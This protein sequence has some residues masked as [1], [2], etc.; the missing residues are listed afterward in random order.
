MHAYF[1]MGE[2]ATTVGVSVFDCPLWLHA[3]YKFVKAVDRLAWVRG[4]LS[5]V[6]YVLSGVAKGSPTELF[7]N[8]LVACTEG[9]WHDYLIPVGQR[10]NV[11][12]QLTLLHIP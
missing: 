3:L 4:R 12:A 5:M 7:I 10:G 2:M 8:Y 1:P 11:L 9:S 6:D